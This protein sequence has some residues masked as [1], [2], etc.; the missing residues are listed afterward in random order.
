MAEK[1][2]LCCS[3]VAL[4]VQRKMRTEADARAMSAAATRWHY[5]RLKQA[6]GLRLLSKLR[7]SR[8]AATAA[9]A[10]T[11]ACTSRGLPIVKLYTSDLSGDAGM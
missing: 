6:Q 5:R 2:L 8:A 11:R 1:G 3:V 7:H 10:R 9:A 4:L